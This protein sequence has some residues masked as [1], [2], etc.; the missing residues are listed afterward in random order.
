MRRAVCTVTGSSC[1]MVWSPIAKRQSRHRDRDLPIKM[2]DGGQARPWVLILKP[3][4]KGAS[5]F[6]S[7]PTLR[8]SA[9]S[10]E[11]GED[12]RGG[13]GVGSIELVDA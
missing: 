2:N 3:K 10:L 12:P 4:H 13:R 11:E 8:P 7:R 9:G 1:I 6:P 5:A